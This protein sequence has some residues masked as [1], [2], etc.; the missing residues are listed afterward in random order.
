LLCVVVFASGAVAQAGDEAGGH[1]EGRIEL[2]N[3]SM[4]VK[5]DLALE[6]GE[7][8]GTIDIPAQGATGLPLTGI[9]I[10]EAK[11][12]ID[13]RFVIDGVPGEPTFLGKL[14]EGEIRGTLMQGGARMRFSLGR[15]VATAAARPQEPKPPFPYEVE[16]ARFRNGER[17]LAGTLTVP[18][19][20]GPFS[21]VLLISGS[22]PQNRDEEIFGHK[23]F[24]VLAD[25]LTRAGV[26]VL[27]VDDP[28]VGGSTG[29]A[30]PPTTADFA[31][32][33]AAAVE[34]LKGDPRVAVER[35][36][37]IGHSEGGVI[38]P[39]VASR[40]DDVSFLVLLAGS[41]V[42]GD[43]LLRRQNQRIFEGAGFPKKRQEKLLGLLEKLFAGLA[44]EDEGER[45]ERVTQVIR[46]QMKANGV[47]DDQLQAEQVVAAANQAD[48]AWMRYFLGYDPRP[49]L[50]ETTI[51]VL[52]LNGDLDVQV[53]AEQNLTAIAA[54]LEEAGND[55]VTIRR[56]PGLNH[57]FQHAKTGMVGEYGTIEETFAPEVLDE[58][59]DWILER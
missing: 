19:G 24:W 22:G 45:R 6:A 44:L 59:R 42:P 31:I 29:Y 50:R 27:R 52:A 14:E 20:A 54:A 43:E 36:G 41:G 12:G 40:R 39:L 8:T 2:P 58:I 48:N 26:A 23:P 46:A 15:D 37:L 10:E 47:P 38:A 35:I 16:E 30:T 55:N 28:G 5:V 11:K 4:G 18:E 32:D 7:W 53:D 33:A 34:Y 17:Q 25:H 56:Y 3:G 21:A 57:L 9:A 49:V 51:P 13:V 1:W